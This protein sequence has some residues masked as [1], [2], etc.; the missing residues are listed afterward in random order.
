MI[1]YGQCCHKNGG[2]WLYDLYK[3]DKNFS[4]FG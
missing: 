1:V 4:R 2:D 3:S